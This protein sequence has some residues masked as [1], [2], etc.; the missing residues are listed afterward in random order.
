MNKGCH[1]LPLD[2]DGVDREMQAYAK[3]LEALT[4]RELWSPAQPPR[5][6]GRGL[7]WAALESLLL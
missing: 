4:P 3:G 5:P 2:L 1:L 6:S 7:S